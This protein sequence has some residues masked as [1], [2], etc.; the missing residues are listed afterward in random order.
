MENPNSFRKVG[1]LEGADKI[2][3]ET[4]FIGTFPGLTKEMMDYIIE[5]LH[6]FIKI[7]SK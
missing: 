1:N 5:E 3:N 7:N 2:M 6:Q 4:L